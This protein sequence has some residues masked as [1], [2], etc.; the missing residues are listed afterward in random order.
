M[1]KTPQKIS[2]Y[3]EFRYFNPHG[4]K[5]YM[6]LK[7][8]D[9]HTPLAFILNLLKILPKHKWKSS[10]KIVAGDV[11]IESEDLEDIMEADET[12]A[13]GWDMPE[14]YP[15]QIAQIAGKKLTTKQSKL[16]ARMDRYDEDGRLINNSGPK[17]KK[18]SAK[19]PNS[20]LVSLAEIAEQTGLNPKSIR[21]TLRKHRVERKYGTWH[22]DE[23]EA[24]RIVKLLEKE[25]DRA[26]H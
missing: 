23:H 19:K 12:L 6:Y 7:F 26:K 11:I 18:S 13:S 3:L 22:F 14:P 10:T 9:L 24:S 1:P 15:T 8:D 25:N 2:T 20:D 4:D 17:P 21:A 5:R 16:A